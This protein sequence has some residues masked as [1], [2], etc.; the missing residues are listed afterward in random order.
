MASTYVN[1][2][3]LNELATGDGAGTW[4]TTTNTNLELIGEALG[5]GTEAITTNADTHTT[6]VADGASDPGRAMY[7]E[8]T[9]TLDSACTITIAPNTL[10]R[11]HFIENGTSGSQNII[12]SQGSGANITIPP[13]DTK[14]VYLDGAGSGAAVVDAFASLSVVDLKVQDDLTVTDDMTVGGDID[15]EGSI[16]VNGTANLDVVDIDG[17]VN[18]A[19]T[20]LVTG[21]LTTTAATVFNGGFASN[22]AST[23]STADNLDTLSLISTDADANV[24]PNLRLY[25]NS[26][27]PAD[28]DQLGKIQ[29]EGRN[30]NSQD[31]IYSEIIN[32]IKDA[33]DGTEDGRIAFNSMV[34]GTLRARLD[35]LPT[36]TVLN[37]GSIDLDFRVESN[38]ATNAFVI[39][40]GNNGIGFGATPRADLHTTW[41]QIFFG[42]K[43]S[44]ISERAGSGGLYGTM[45]TDNLYIDSDTGTYAAIETNESSKHVQEAGIHTFYTAASASAGAAP[46]FIENIRM[47]SSAVTVNE[48]SADVDFRVESDNL[49]HALFVQGSDGYVGI[50][51]S[52]PEYPLEI[53]NVFS[54]SIAYQRTGVS[55]KKWGFTSDNNGTFW[56]NITDN[57]SAMTL[58]NAG[59]ATFPGAVNAGAGLRISTDGSNNGVIQT[60]G[61]D[62]DMF[63]SGDDGGSGINALI[64]DMSAAGAATFNSTVLSTGVLSVGASSA[65][66][67]GAAT[68]DANV[69]ELGAGY[70]NLGRDDTADA[71][72]LAFSKNGSLHSSILTDNNDLHIKGNSSNLGIR[73]D[74]NDGGSAITALRLDMADA[75]NAAFSAGATFAR[76]VNITLAGNSD[77]LTLTTTDGDASAGPN[78]RFFRNSGSPANNDLAG[79]ISFD[80]KN[81]AGQTV[82]LAGIDNYILDVA[83]GSE[84]GELTITTMVGGTTRN[85]L[86]FTNTSTIVNESGIDMD[87]RVESSAKTH[88]F[89]VQGSGNEIFFGASSTT[90]PQQNNFVNINTA[91]GVSMTIGGHS[92]THT[93][94][95]FKHDGANT[96][97]SVVVNASG[98]TYNTSSDYRLKENVVTNWDATTRLK[99]LKPSRFNFIKDAGTTVDGFLAHEVESIVPEAISGTKDALFT[100]EDETNNKGIEGQPNYQGIDQGKLVPLLVKT[101][102]ELE[103]RITALES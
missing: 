85:R 27:S 93:S 84:D 28:S 24:A 57:V 64:L 2:L 49:T 50:G 40:G 90:Y 13:G 43:G 86:D 89:F 25:R 47:S 97:G 88:A 17:A 101:I 70:L 23:I 20:A 100:A 21:V 72:Q 48:G 29:F 15:L 44:I 78:L 22:A 5:Y 74:G 16:D 56:S 102:Q 38:G 87:F 103:A 80:C 67:I 12:I 45:I 39:D 1:D 83:D 32:Q 6:T 11:M 54:T 63:F 14:A 52:S 60:L 3:R 75:G 19:T 65:V 69:A 37:D 53:A 55:A 33:S 7:L 98:T 79:T 77:N 9:G 42:Q 51:D 66:G 26:G 58:T 91:S 10:S 36:E 35:I 76:D 96:V 82:T 92:G 34:A 30:D 18:M 71:V 68:A 95:V 73:F 81:N 46:T 99:Q 4:G 8:Y 31:V 59:A 62:K 61:Q 41:T 94:M